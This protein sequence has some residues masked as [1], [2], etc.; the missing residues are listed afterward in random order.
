MYKRHSVRIGNLI[1][2]DNHPIYVQTMLNTSPTDYKASLTQLKRVI[3]RGAELV[4]ISV[5]GRETIRV[6]GKLVENSPVPLIADIHFNYKMALEAIKAGAAKIRINP[7]NIG[8]K[9]KIEKIIDLA[10]DKD[11]SIRIGV[12]SGSLP[13]HILEKYNHPTPDAM[14]AT[15]KEYVDFFEECGFFNIILS[16]KSSSLEDTIR[17]NELLH[18]NFKYPIHIG[19][20]EAGPIIQGLT[21]SI[22]ALSSILKN[23]IGNTIRISLTAD[24]VYEVDAAFYLLK[25]LGLRDIGIELITCPTCGRTSVNL[26]EIVNSVYERLPLFKYKLKLAIMGCA[27]NGPGEAKEADMGIAFG[28]DEALYFE[29]G[30]PIEK[31]NKDEAIDFILDKVKGFHIKKN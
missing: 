17:I 3:E 18:K 2:G 14:I 28:R 22:L 12:N 11:V 21:K 23:G 13:V 15:M 4:R 20:T 30:R 9:N 1:F 31:V 24:P 5:P 7:G 16:C 27:V 8:R 26:I 19:L 10:K 25:F 6:F 29:R